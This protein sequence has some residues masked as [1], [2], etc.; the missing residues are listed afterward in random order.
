MNPIALPETTLAMRAL[1]ARSCKRVSSLFALFLMGLVTG[2]NP[3]HAVIG[4]TPANWGA[5]PWL[6]KNVAMYPGQ[7]QWTDRGCS[8][9]VIDRLYAVTAGHCLNGPYPYKVGVMFSDGDVIEVVREIRHPQYSWDAQGRKET[10]GFTSDSV[11]DIG[12]QLLAEPVRGLLN[13]RIHHLL[14][15]GKPP[16]ISPGMSARVVGWGATQQA[17]TL[18]AP[19]LTFSMMLQKLDVVVQNSAACQSKLDFA[20]AAQTGGGLTVSPFRFNDSHICAVSAKPG[21]GVCVGDSGPLFTSRGGVEQLLGFVTDQLSISYE[22][23]CANG[24]DVYTRLTSA[25]LSW[26]RSVVGNPLLPLLFPR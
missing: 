7:S 19:P 9:V 15:L 12:L 10:F 20:T 3:A 11:A 2:S 23:P 26:I 16:E 14:L 24:V 25:H 4:G 17:Q 6:V 5:Y 1:R 8:S 22:Q 13:G 21:S 18:L